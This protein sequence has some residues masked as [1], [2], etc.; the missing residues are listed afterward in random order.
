MDFIKDKNKY[1]KIFSGYSVMALQRLGYSKNNIIEFLTEINE[2]IKIKTDED[3][4]EIIESINDLNKFIIDNTAQVYFE[5]I[6]IPAKYNMVKI[7]DLFEKYN[8][9]GKEYNY[10][11]KK[12]CRALNKNGIIYIKDLYDKTKKD[13]MYIHVIGEISYKFF[14]N[15]LKQIFRENE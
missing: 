13:I 1:A 14:I 4:I 7:S 3:A 11:G 9:M 2:L 5:G 15:A 6:M 8:F 12:I 10:I